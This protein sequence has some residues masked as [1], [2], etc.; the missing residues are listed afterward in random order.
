M[1][2]GPHQPN[3][4]TSEAIDKMLAAHRVLGES[5]MIKTDTPPDQVTDDQVSQVIDR[6]KAYLKE[7]KIPQARLAKALVIG[8]STVSQ[9]LSGTYAA[10]AKP[11]IIAMDRWLDRRLEADAMPEVNTYVETA[12]AQRIQLAAKRAIIASDAGLDTRISLVWGDPGCGKTMALKAVAENVGG[13][14]ITCGDEMGSSSAI[15]DAIAKAMNMQDLGR[16]RAMRFHAVCDALRGTGKLLVVDEIP[17][18]AGWP[19]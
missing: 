16:N 8:S 6:V 5:R 10:D 18:P 1:T 19:R 7:N 12:V 14:M 13:I 4:L 3:P 2:Q 17:R 15:L 11:I 9:V